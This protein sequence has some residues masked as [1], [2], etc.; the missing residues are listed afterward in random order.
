MTNF[1]HFLYRSPRRCIDLY[2][3]IIYFLW[4]LSA[5]I[6]MHSCLSV[7]TLICRDLSL[8]SFTCVL[9]LTCF[10]AFWIMLF[11]VLQKQKLKCQKDYAESLK[12]LEKQSAVKQEKYGQQKVNVG[13]S[14]YGIDQKSKS[15]VLCN[16]LFTQ[17]DNF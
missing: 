17:Y 4:F 10:I 12:R 7:L 2:G 8:Y 5:E 11:F 9:I 6:F 15:Q 14:D 16:H 1:F 3:M 13:L